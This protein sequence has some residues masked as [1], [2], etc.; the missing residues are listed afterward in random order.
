[1]AKK[2]LLRHMN[3]RW[4]GLVQARAARPP[5]LGAGK[6]SLPWGCCSSAPLAPY[7]L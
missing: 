2:P 3:G 6:A 5:E 1:M 4:R 7:S